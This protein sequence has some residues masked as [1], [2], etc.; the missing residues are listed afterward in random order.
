VVGATDFS[1]E[2]T[3][4]SEGLDGS[5]GLVFTGAAELRRESS[6]GRLGV[7]VADEGFGLTSSEALGDVEGVFVAGTVFGRLGLQPAQ[8]QAAEINMLTIVTLGKDISL[9]IAGVY[10]LCNR[11]SPQTGMRTA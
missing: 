10:R 1:V 2:T 4:S 11:L 6:I 3:A 8:A 9:F 5:C 7:E